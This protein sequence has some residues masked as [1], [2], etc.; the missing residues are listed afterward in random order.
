MTRETADKPAQAVT[1]FSC[2]VREPAGHFPAREYA[3]FQSAASQMLGALEQEIVFKK[4][5][6][7]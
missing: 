5:A 3:G 4:T 2:E 6:P 1:K 7:D